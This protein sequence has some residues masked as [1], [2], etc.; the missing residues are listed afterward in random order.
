MYL[1]NVFV[2]IEI[3]LNEKLNEKKDNIKI[4]QNHES[5]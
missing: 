4:T 2:F 3:V 5:N 1:E